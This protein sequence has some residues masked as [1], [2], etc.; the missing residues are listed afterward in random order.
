MSVKIKRMIT[1][2]LLLLVVLAPWQFYIT[3]TSAVTVSVVQLLAIATIMLWLFAEVKYGIGQLE[4][5]EFWPAVFLLTMFIASWVAR[6][7]AQAFKYFCKWSTAVMLFFVTVRVVRDVK[8]VRHCLTGGLGTAALIMLLGMAEFICGFDTLFRFV[9]QYRQLV[10]VFAGPGTLRKFLS[11]NMF[12]N[13]MN[14]F[15]WIPETWTYWVRPFGTFIA[16]S[17][18]NLCLGMLGVF[19]PYF[20]YTGKHSRQRSLCLIGGM[21]GVITLILTFARSSWLALL[22]VLI[23]GFWLQGKRKRIIVV[24]LILGS[25][26]G[27]GILLSNNFNMIVQNRIFSVFGETSAQSRLEL[28]RQA[29]QIIVNQPVSGIGLAQY[30]QGLNIFAAAPFRRVPA[31]SDYL[32]IW[33]EMGI[34]GVIAFIMIIGQGLVLSYRIVKNS[35][36]EIH[37]LALGFLLMWIWFAVQAVFDTNIFD[38]KI[39][40]LFWVLAGLNMVVYRQWKEKITQ[41][42][43]D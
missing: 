6:E 30:D 13:Q 9:H 39:S 2:M 35:V 21:L 42:K 3:I 25:I 33:A 17:A 14:W 40:I 1:I 26:I 16:V 31:H 11:E 38:D 5:F 4:K 34:V 7:R 43:R 27:A 29:W 19:I 37:C 28:W 22:S 23:V 15:Y 41:D 36:K 8:T 32:Q 12:L 18:F 10:G 20:Y 24:L